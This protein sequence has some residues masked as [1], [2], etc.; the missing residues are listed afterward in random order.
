MATS[1][2]F[3]TSNT[4]V[5][6][7]I[8][9]NVNS[10]SITNNT[11]NVSVTVRFW[12]TNTGY[13]TYG[14]G[15]VYAGIA[16]TSYSQGVVP[17]QAITNSGIDLFSR[18]MTINHNTDGT[19]TI[20]VSAYISHNAPL[21]SSDQGF[22]VT[23]PTIPRASS[24]SGGSGN[25]GSSTTIN[26]SRASSSFTH[27]L[28]WQQGTSGWN[29]I[30]SNVGTSYSWTIPTSFYARIPNANSGT[31]T[32]WC[33]TYSG[34]TYIGNSST[35]FT[36]KV[37]NSNP[38]FTA[39]QLTYKDSDTAIAAIT[40]NNQLIVRNQSNLQATFTAATAQNSATISQYQVTF[41]GATQNFTSATTVNYGKVNLSQNATIQVKV[42]DSR[43]N[44]VTVSK[45]VTILDWIPPITNATAARVN[46]FEK[47]TNLLANVQI[48]SVQEIN[49]L[50][51]LKYRTK[52]TS[53]TDWNAWVDFQ[54]NIGTQLNLDN[55]FAWDVQVEAKDKFGTTT[56]D[57]LVTK[58]MPI[59]FFDTKKLSVGINCLPEKTNSLEVNGKTLFDMIYPI[60]SIYLSVSSVNPTA[61]FPGT[62]WVTWGTGK[63][64]VGVDTS[65]SQYNTVEKQGGQVTHRHQFRIGMH[66]W[67]GAAVGEGN[68]NSTGAYY[69][70]ESRYDGWARSLASISTTINSGLTTGS[71]TNSPAGKYSIGQTA[72]Q[73]YVSPYITCYMWK[74]TA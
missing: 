25:I 63:H 10:Q 53:D 56:Q 50:Q 34:S 2:T 48:S 65:V 9:V 33:E 18:T 51:T 31:G 42:V 24:V 57:L 32:I 15:T 54:N 30:A 67:Y 46:N 41:N 64:P 23:L 21:T 74:R 39:S 37:T 70:S 36:F 49:A 71:T 66:F 55:L 5:K 40:Q 35:S 28:Y 45:T 59:A 27:V 60:G 52:K 13:S 26:I 8:T 4:Y 22:N 61:V 17:S 20:W 19:K 68:G 44:S 1:S 73:D 11:S 69:D 29:W 72:T 14:T 12:R 47:Q 7:N 62:T 43:G 6:Y 38:V 3:G 16:G 58:G